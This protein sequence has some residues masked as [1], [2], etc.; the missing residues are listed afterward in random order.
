[1]IGAEAPAA[2]QA[3]IPGLAQGRIVMYRLSQ[4]D[5]DQINRR[6]TTG[7]QIALRMLNGNWHAGAQAHIGSQVFPGDVLPAMLIRI[8]DP[9]TGCANL[10]VHL[11][12]TDDYWAKDVPFGF[13]NESH[14]MGVWR[15]PERVA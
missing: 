13:S 12:G 7:E 1:M 4:E 3:T 8:L 15:W 9:V 6:R 5:A 11:D 14:P 2:P 10:R